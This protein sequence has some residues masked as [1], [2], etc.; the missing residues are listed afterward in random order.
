ME[1]LVDSRR[2]GLTKSN[3]QHR[4]GLQMQKTQPRRTTAERRR[5]HMPTD[6][7]SI[8]LAP[9]LHFAMLKSN[10]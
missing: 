4:K 8:L 9:N 6:P 5:T 10:S 1:P 7:R 2:S 3:I